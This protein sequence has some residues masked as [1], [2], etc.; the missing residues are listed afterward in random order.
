MDCSKKIKELREST[1]D[2]DKVYL[3]KYVEKL[4]WYQ[5]CVKIHFEKT[6]TYELI[7]EVDEKLSKIRIAEKNG[8]I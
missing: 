8:K 6:K 4:K 7:N 1:E 2:L 5:I 3:Y